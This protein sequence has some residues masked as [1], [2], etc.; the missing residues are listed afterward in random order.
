MLPARMMVKMSNVHATLQIGKAVERYAHVSINIFQNKRQNIP[1]PIKSGYQLNF[2]FSGRDDD[3]QI[4]I[5]F[6]LKDCIFP[7]LNKFLR[8]R[9]NNKYFNNNES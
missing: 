1:C 9:K 4:C 5:F 8:I 3:Y 7:F 2:F 6:H